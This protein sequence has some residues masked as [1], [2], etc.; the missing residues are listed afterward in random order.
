[1]L[2]LSRKVGER[3][4]VP[5]LGVTLTVLG[6]HGG[7]VRLGIAAPPR[8]AVLREE[9]LRKPPAPAAGKLEKAFER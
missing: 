3:I 5:N 1:M 4:V 9:V 6:C 2:V 8:V 7:Q